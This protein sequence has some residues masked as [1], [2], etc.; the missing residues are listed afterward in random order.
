MLRRMIRAYG[1]RVAEADDVDLG[2]MALVLDELQA[3]IASAV[4]G[5]RANGASWSEIGRAFGISRQAAQ[6]RFGS[7]LGAVSR[8]SG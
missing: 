5:Q 4:E 3:A 8:T 1:K 7:D 6:Q 2:D